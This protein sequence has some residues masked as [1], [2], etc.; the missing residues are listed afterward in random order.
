MF[1]AP[2]V[3]P[4]VLG[5]SVCPIF[6]LLIETCGTL[7]GSAEIHSQVNWFTLLEAMVSPSTPSEAPVW[8]HFIKDSVCLSYVCAACCMFFV[9]WLCWHSERHCRPSTW[10][11][12]PQQTGFKGNLRLLIKPFEQPHLPFKILSAALHCSAEPAMSCCHL[13]PHSVERRSQSR[14]PND[15]LH[16]ALRNES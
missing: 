10:C 5:C 1:S 4:P 8:S 11:S 2:L 9:R 14:G 16:L 13:S 12:D 7:R 6:F 15:L 3:S